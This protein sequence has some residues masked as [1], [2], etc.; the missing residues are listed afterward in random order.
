[1]PCIT[2]TG[3]SR[4]KELTIEH[5]W[6]AAPPAAAVSAA[7][8]WDLLG[9]QQVKW[10]G[11]SLPDNLPFQWVEK[12]YMLQSEYDEMLANPNGFTIK[13]LWPRIATTLEP[14]SRLSQMSRTH[15]LTALYQIP[16]L[17]PVSLEE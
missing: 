2:G 5:D 11:S 12:E 8:P 1:M 6:D 9:L 17:Y 16:T 4:L 15:S 10:P 7:Q 14:L 3:V 13:K